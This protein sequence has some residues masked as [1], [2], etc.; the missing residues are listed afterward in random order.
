MGKAH[1]SWPNI[2][3]IVGPQ[4]T[5]TDWLNEW[6]HLCEAVCEDE[7]YKN[8]LR[9]DSS[10]YVAKITNSHEL[11]SFF[12]VFFFSFSDLNQH[13]A[14]KEPQNKLSTFSLWELQAIAEYGG[15]LPKVEPEE[16]DT[17][18]NN[19]LRRELLL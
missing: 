4:W 2:L 12:V 5:V 16:Q 3:I 10:N 8:H 1:S 9:N 11:K 14:K 6:T 18:W 13:Q 19:P 7:V 15:Q 17:K